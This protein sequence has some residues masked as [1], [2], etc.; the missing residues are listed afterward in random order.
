CSNL[1]TCVLSAYWK[2]L[3]NYHRFSGM[4]FGPETP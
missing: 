4:G 2:D 1:S 3:N